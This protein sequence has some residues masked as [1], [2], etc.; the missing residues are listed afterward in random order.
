MTEER[1]IEEDLKPSEG[2]YAHAGVR[3]GLSLA[4]FIGGPLAEFFS[5]VIAPPL[6]ARRDSWMIEIFTQLKKLEDHVEG[7]KIENLA[8]NEIFIS[9]LFYATQAAMRTHQKEKL[10]ALRNVVINSAQK[11]TIDENLQLMFLNLIDKYTPWHLVL[12]QFCND[13]REFRRQRGTKNSMWSIGGLGTLIEDTFD[14]LKAKQDFYDQI[15]KEL[16]SDGLMQEG[17][18]MHAGMTENGMYASRTTE[19]GK[20]FLRFIILKFD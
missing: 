19:I 1:D 5:M 14:E 17:M 20:Q 16:I 8:Q 18:Y 4:P 15:I 11:P 12:L 3:A 9:T 7:F 6:E 13:P 10:E 2:D